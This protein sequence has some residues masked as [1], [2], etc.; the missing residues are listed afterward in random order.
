V[1]KENL[2][3]FTGNFLFASINSC[4]GNNKSRRDDI[5]S[6]LNVMVYLLNNNTLPWSD[7]YTRFKPKNYEF[8]DF[9]KERLDIK[10][11]KE[12]FRMIPKSMR[13]IFK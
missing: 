12:L 1:K 2:E 6:I 11:C 13:E 7:F 10:Y 9:L 3:K 8:K 4:R 5:H